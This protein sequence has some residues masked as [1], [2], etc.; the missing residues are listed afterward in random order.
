MAKA[1]AFKPDLTQPQLFLDD[2]WVHDTSRIQRTWHQPKKYIEPVIK[3]E[4]PWEANCPVMYGSLLHYEGKFRAWYCGWTKNMA[5]RACYA[6][7]VDG[8][9]WIKPKLG[10]C[11]VNGSKD[12]NV[13]L[14]SA[15]PKQLI[16]DLTVI[17]DPEDKNW[18]L[19]MIYWNSQPHGYHA[20][21]SAD[22]I[23]WEHIGCV[24]PDWGD[25]FNAVPC[26][27]DGKYILFGRAPGGL[28]YRYKNRVSWRT[29]SSDL[30]RWSKP[31]LVMTT[32]HE[33]PPLMETYSI[34]AFPYNDLLMGSIERM[35]MSPDKLDTEI[36]WSRDAGNSWIRSRTRPSFIPWGD[37]GHF[38]D[39]WVNL[40]ASAPI[41]VNDELW[42]YYSGRTGAHGAPF[43]HNYGGIGLATLRVDGYCSL[44]AIE[45]DGYVKINPMTWPGGELVINIDL[46]RNNLSHPRNTISG[47]VRAEVQDATGKP[48]K[49]YAFE[50]C[51]V[52]AG[53]GDHILKWKKN[54]LDK[55]KGRKVRLVFQY[56]DG[57]LYSFR[58]AKQS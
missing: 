12:N 37:A 15:D 39:T 18:P 13:I 11:E 1:P 30:K 47:R 22:G 29:E 3:A 57:H 21:R 46:R 10:I 24:L 58:A 19:K 50:D 52:H 42:F 27:I 35:H 25:R 51:I 9:N 31:K 5:P 14:Q 43:P 32:H 4:H 56:N 23:H 55:L 26:K 17:E 38:D 53:N 36:I 7:S 41:R 48:I 33:D 44:R 28:D 20:A 45:K 16:D 40:P 6:E 49:G 34:T 54:K 8:I 2:Y